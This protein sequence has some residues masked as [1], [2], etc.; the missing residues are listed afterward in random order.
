MS[1]VVATLGMIPYT[2]SLLEQAKEDP[3]QG[4]PA[5]AVLIASGLI[6]IG[7]S[8]GAIA[9]GL[10]TGSRFHWGVPPLRAWLAG[11]P[12]AVLRVRRS[13]A[14]ALATGMALGVSVA[15]YSG[16]GKADPQ[17]GANPIIMPP[18]WEGLL[19]SASAGIRE[20]IW[21]RLGCL[22]FLAWVGTR[23]AHPVLRTTEEPPAPI[24]WIANLLSALLFAAIH[25]PQAQLL[26]G[27]SPEIL[28]F[29]ILGNGVPGMVF[30]W[31][32]W[33]RGLIA[34]MTAHFGFDLVLKVFLPLF[35]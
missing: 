1:C 13:L 3:F 32:Y 4:L 33:R 35:F 21:F 17:N 22:T 28:L 31:F 15:I 2:L 16:M 5:S 27:L 24:V 23:L 18:A 26:L 11:G 12:E 14:P 29:V 8:A 10:V 25:L 19:A 30:G 20:E 9:I 34:A 6:E 7:M